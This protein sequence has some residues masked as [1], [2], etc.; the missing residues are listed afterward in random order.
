MISALSAFFELILSSLIYGQL[1]TSSAIFSIIVFFSVALVI[2]LGLFILRAVA[3]CIMAKKQKIKWW[4]LGLIPYA[5]YIVLGKVAGSAKIFSMHF[6]NIGIVVCV[7]A[8]IYDVINVL[9]FLLPFAQVFV[10][11]LDNVTITEEVIGSLGLG[12]FAYYAQL[13]S[14][15]CEIAFIFSYAML[16]YA[17]FSKYA[18]QKRILY[19]L[20]SMIQP[21]FGILLLTVMNNRAYSSVDEFYRE[22][23]AKKFGQTYNPYQN[24]FSTNENPFDEQTQKNNDNPFDEY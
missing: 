20:L 13:I 24:P 22:K 16:A 18:P 4:W 11:L 14:Y 12:M 21:L 2:Y 7:S 17:I 6:K 1:S 3:T 5:N 19:T 15:F 10:M 9:V 8:L 23:M